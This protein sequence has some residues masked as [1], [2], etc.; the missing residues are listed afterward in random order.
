MFVE[1]MLALALLV[2]ENVPKEKEKTYLPV[3]SGAMRKALILV[4]LT[5][6]LVGL[7]VGFALG[8]SVGA[9]RGVI[10]LHDPGAQVLYD[11]Q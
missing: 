8:Y 3:G 2:A 9:K 1:V 10:I 6:M 11:E 4:G 7:V 5:G